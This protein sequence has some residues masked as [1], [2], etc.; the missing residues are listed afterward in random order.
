[1]NIYDNPYEHRYNSPY[2]RFRG[3]ASGL[4]ERGLPTPVGRTTRV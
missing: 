3:G 2:Q 4:N 1:M